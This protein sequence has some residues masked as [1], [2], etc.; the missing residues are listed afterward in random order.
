MNEVNYIVRKL[1]TIEKK[2]F[3]KFFDC[4]N[5]CKH[6]ESDHMIILYRFDDITTNYKQVHYG[7]WKRIN[8]RSIYIGMYYQ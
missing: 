6:W 4:R 1:V 3:T 7:T 2:F 8:L 5:W